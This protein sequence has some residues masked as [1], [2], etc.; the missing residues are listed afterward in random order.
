MTDRRKNRDEA[1]I[2]RIVEGLGS[3]DPLGVRCVWPWQAV[4]E[5][6]DTTGLEPAEPEP[7]IRR[8]AALCVR[9]IVVVAATALAGGFA[10]GIGELFA[11]SWT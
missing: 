2:T 6:R 9:V 1:T 7:P 3:E 5:A 8:L 4:V 10:F 11:I